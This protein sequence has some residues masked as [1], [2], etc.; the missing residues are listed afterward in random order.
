MVLKKCAIEVVL[1]TVYGVVQAN[2]GL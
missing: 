1:V 2:R